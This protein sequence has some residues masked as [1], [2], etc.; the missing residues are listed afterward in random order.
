MGMQDWG[1]WGM[2]DG[3]WDWADPQSCTKISRT[4]SSAS[5]VW[6]VDVWWWWTTY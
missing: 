4:C 1:D 3:E 6:A 2:G 5:S